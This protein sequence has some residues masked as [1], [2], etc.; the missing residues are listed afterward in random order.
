[1]PTLEDS[2]GP[3]ADV[4]ADV[5]AGANKSAPVE[6]SK[7]INSE[8][9]D[10]QLKNLQTNAFQFESETLQIT[11]QLD[12]LTSQLQQAE[13]Q[14][15]FAQIEARDYKSK[16]DG[17]QESLESS[18]HELGQVKKELQEQFLTLVSTRIEMAFNARLL[19]TNG[20]PFRS[21]TPDNTAESVEGRERKAVHR[22]LITG[23]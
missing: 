12:K 22:S 1:M 2:N 11:Q 5:E 7:N 17:L 6:M 14:S 13:A 19:N 15:K 4:E 9:D 20:T 10:K 16:F 18:Q 21:Y 8:G 3:P 23:C